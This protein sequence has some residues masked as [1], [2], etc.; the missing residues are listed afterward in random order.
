M[1][2]GPNPYKMY[3]HMNQMVQISDM[4]AQIK[5]KFHMTLFKHILPQILQFQRCQTKNVEIHAF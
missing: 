3:M 2:T 4:L 1:C 5:I